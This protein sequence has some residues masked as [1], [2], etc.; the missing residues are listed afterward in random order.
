MVN[1]PEHENAFAFVF[2]EIKQE[3]SRSHQHNSVSNINAKRKVPIADIFGED[4][5]S[6]CKRFKALG[7]VGP[8]GLV[9][10]DDCRS[11]MRIYVIS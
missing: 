8:A 3:L 1:P 5:V 9:S 11:Q 10:G 6:D 4:F 7:I 2:R